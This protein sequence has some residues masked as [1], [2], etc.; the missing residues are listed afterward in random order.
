MKK[1][2]KRSLPEV[3][4]VKS[5]PKLQFFGDLLHDP[6]L[7]H[8]NRRSVAGGMAVGLFI[9]FIP[10]PMQMLLAAAFAIAFRVNLP[11]SVSLVWVTNP[12]TIPPIFYFA[13]KLGTVLLG[14][15]TEY[16][17]FSL[18]FEWLINSLDIFWQPLLLGSFVLGSFS[19]LTGYLL[20]NFLWR[21]QVS[22]LWQ[23]RREKRL[24][25]LLFVEKQE[26]GQ[27]KKL[28]L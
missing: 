27:L 8:L 24:K 10:L 19:A 5:H 28:P 13:Y 20:I 16:I 18:S 15:P 21:L 26:L 4:H 6:N 14:L 12:I 25:K 23:D 9:A 17:E 7:W 11:L 1:F 22:R 2:F 3:S